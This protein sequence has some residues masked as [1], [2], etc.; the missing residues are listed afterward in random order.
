MLNFRY[1]CLDQLNISIFFLIFLKL[2]RYTCITLEAA[3]DFEFGQSLL[4]CLA[5][6]LTGYYFVLLSVRGE[7]AQKFG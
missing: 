5:D 6:V 4:L 1:F 7:H 2:I 3:K